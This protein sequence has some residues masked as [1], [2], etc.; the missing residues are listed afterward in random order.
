MSEKR[1]SY[2]NRN[3]EDYQNALRNLIKEY[4]PQIANDFDDAS[5]GSWLIDIMA[6]IGDNL[7]Y[8]IDRAYS[9][10]NLESANLKSSVYSIARSNGLKIPG[11]SASIA[12]ESFTCTLP[13]V[14]KNGMPAWEFAPVIKRGTRLMSGSQIFEVMED[15]DFAEQ[16]DSN[17]ISNRKINPK[18]NSNGSI[19]SYEITKYSTVVAGESKI[20]KQVISATDVKPFMEIIIPDSNIMNI[21]SIIFKE[22]GDYNVNPTMNEFYMNR[23]YASPS[24]TPTQ[25]TIYRYFE[26][27]SLVEQYRWGEP[28][29]EGTISEGTAEKYTYGYFDEGKEIFV[30]TTSISKGKWIPIT[31]KFITEFTDKGYLKVIFGSGETAGQNSD[32]YSEASDY[33]QYQIT[34]MIRNNFLGVLP[35]GG[36]TMFV[37]YR[38]GGGRASN[39]G[40]GTINQISYLN[41]E[42]GKACLTKENA[43][44]RSAI[45]DSIRVIN[46]TP[47]VSGK[48]S[49][50]VEEIKAMIKYNSGAQERCVTVKD[51]ENR[52]L[53]M[54]SK[55]GT[56][57]RVRATEENNKVIVYLL[58]INNQGNL[59]TT[60]PEQLARNITEYLSMYRSINDLVEIKSGRIINISVECDI[61]VDKN[62]N[63]SDVVLNVIN[64]IK[65]Y[66]SVEKFSMGDKIFIGDLEKEISRIDGVINLIDT[67]IYNE[68]GGDYSISQ[69]S[70]ITYESDEDGRDEIDIESSDYI[71]NGDKDEMFEIKFPNKD[72]K[73]R[74]KTI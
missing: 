64:K 54:P 67:R 62:Y 45:K 58:G 2:L 55:Y 15:I 23:E 68:H 44:I 51:Y 42:I 41:A 35:K 27:N 53:L 57:F 65:D 4:Y 29:V 7:S 52:I 73:V 20:Y 59:T 71:L 40:K 46:T 43:A 72:I 49:P 14:S 18:R 70:Q 56:P 34:K 33:T 48:D 26:V 6:A 3:F 28:E 10:T 5:V 50:S 66:L 31:Q 36:W 37:L 17:G 9:E 16:F 1:I 30:P 47:S 69:T 24:E 21:E 8:Y 13:V 19:A 12:E 25:T 39:V 38:V 74:A 22:G 32:I 11:P 63:T 61:Y 60:I